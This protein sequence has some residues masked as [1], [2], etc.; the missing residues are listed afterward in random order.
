MSTY[1][2]VSMACVKRENTVWGWGWVSVSWVG[3]SAAGS[4]RCVGEFYIAWR[5]VTLACQSS[6]QAV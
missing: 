3:R 4:Q 1:N 2:N 6:H 5:V